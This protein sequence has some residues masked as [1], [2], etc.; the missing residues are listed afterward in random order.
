MH[1]D[2]IAVGKSDEVVVAVEAAAS[3]LGSLLVQDV[4]HD[5]GLQAAVLEALV[6]RTSPE[7][8]PAT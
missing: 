8:E 5:A 1:P 2:A 7:A 3:R 4:L 6:R